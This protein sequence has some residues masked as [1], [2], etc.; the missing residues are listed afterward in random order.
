MQVAFKVDRGCNTA[1]GWCANS[2]CLGNSET[3]NSFAINRYCMPVQANQDDALEK[4]EISGSELLKES[5]RMYVLFDML[6]QNKNLVWFEYMNQF[7]ENICNELPDVETCSYETMAQ[8]GISSDTIEAIKA[9]VTATI[10]SL[11]NS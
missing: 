8:V 1:N 6:P 5:L 7:D 2:D 10:N 3:E 9:N 11:N 4:G